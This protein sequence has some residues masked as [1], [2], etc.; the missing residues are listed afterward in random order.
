MRISIGEALILARE[1]LPTSVNV[2]VCFYTDDS[3]NDR[4]IY[5]M[6][7]EAGVSKTALWLTHFHMAP[8]F[9]EA[10]QMVEKVIKAID[11]K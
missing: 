6:A 8:A 4:I 10:K 1:K 9:T 5:A 7:K 11:K 3:M 2:E